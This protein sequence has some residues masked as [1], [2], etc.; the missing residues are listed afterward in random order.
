MRSTP[1]RRGF[2]R[3]TRLQGTACGSLAADRL[4]ERFAQ[5]GVEDRAGSQ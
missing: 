1:G 2:G 4:A 3:S 5:R